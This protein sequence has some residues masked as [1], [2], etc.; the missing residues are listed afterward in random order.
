MTTQGIAASAWH[1][2]LSL[3]RYFEQALSQVFAPAVPVFDGMSAAIDGSALTITFSLLG[4]PNSVTSQT[5]GETIFRGAL[6]TT[7][8]GSEVARLI[9]VLPFHGIAA[10]VSAQV[11]YDLQSGTRNGFLIGSAVLFES[12]ADART[13][14]ADWASK[15]AGAELA[16]NIREIMEILVQLPVWD[17][18]RLLTE[19][20]DQVDDPEQRARLAELKAGMASSSSAGR[21][22]A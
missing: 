3:C 8:E 4:L 6:E 5:M 21:E 20:F 1:D 15:M 22:A 13:H 7:Q 16:D 11:G 18:C 10:S 19:A 17:A 9:C 12:L 14:A 2:G